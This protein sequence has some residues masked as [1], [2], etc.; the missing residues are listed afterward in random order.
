MRRSMYGVTA[1][2]M[3]RAAI[4]PT[5]TTVMIAVKM[6]I[7]LDLPQQEQNRTTGDAVDWWT[8]D[9]LH[10]GHLTLP[11]GTTARSAW[12]WW[13]DLFWFRDD[14][15]LSRFVLARRAA[16]LRCALCWMLSSVAL[17]FPICSCI[18]QFNVLTV[19]K[20]HGQRMLESASKVYTRRGCLSIWSV[21]SR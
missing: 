13:I 17:R 4:L 19:R 18:S 9:G 6:R 5:L 11:A 16:C 12:K 10:L 20:A 1:V 15:V 21:F 2:T 7:A 14:R 8:V 3:K